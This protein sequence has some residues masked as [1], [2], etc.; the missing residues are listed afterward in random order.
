MSWSA[1][2]SIDFI[3][4]FFLFFFILSE[5]NSL[6]LNKDEEYTDVRLL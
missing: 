2:M 1:S 4:N 3:I 6:W 5:L